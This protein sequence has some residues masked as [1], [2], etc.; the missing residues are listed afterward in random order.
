MKKK[1][2]LNL[3]S[4][5]SYDRPL[6]IIHGISNQFKGLGFCPSSFFSKKWVSAVLFCVIIAPL[7]ID[8]INY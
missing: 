7:F 2:S 3:A 5:I 1:I 4:R 6:Q 8:L